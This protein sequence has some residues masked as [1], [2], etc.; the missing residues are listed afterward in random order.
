MI[1][2]HRGASGYLPE[3]TLAAYQLAI[4]QGADYIEPDLVMTKDGV[5]I[6]RHE[7]EISET[8]DVATVFPE[9]KAT[10]V[11]DGEPITGWFVEDFTLKEIKRL[12]ARERLSFRNQSHNGLYQI[13]TLTEIIDL[14]AQQSKKRLIL[15][16]ARATG[17]E[18]AARMPEP[19]SIMPGF[20][21]GQS[22]PDRTR[23]RRRRSG[24][25]A[26]LTRQLSGCCR[27]LQPG[28]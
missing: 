22:S 1:I 6:S 19:P 18:N 17:P 11:I 26:S 2:A 14:L 9:R 20:W 25:C 28:D 16:G 8:T 13:P 7:N 24:R 5:L 12:K 23:R 21:P 27:R 10:K 4:E 3:H 15:G